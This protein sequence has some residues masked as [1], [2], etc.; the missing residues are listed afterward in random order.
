MIGKIISG[1][2]NIFGGN[3]ADR[4]RKEIEPIVLKINEHFASYTQLSNDELRNKTNEFIQRI[5]LHLTEIDGRITETREQL[6]QTPEDQTDLRDGLFHEIDELEKSRDS[7]LEEILAEILPE[8]FAVVKEAAR[9]LTENASLTFTATDLDREIAVNRNHVQIQGEKA[10]YSNEW[11]AAGG[12]IRWNMV[13]YDVQL[14]GGIALHRGKI[15]EMATG[16][17][18]T[19]V[20]T[21]PVYLNAL[22]KRG[23][24]VVT[25]NDYLAR[26]DCEWN[27]PLYNFLGLSV[28]CL[29][30][31][32]PN[33]TTRRKAYLADI[34]YGTN[35]EFGFD[36]LRDNM[37]HG[38]EEQVQKKHHFAIVDEVDSVLI[39]DARTPLII[40]GPTPHGDDQQ[41]DALK[42]RIQKLVE[43]QKKYI[44]TALNDAKRLIGEGNTGSKEGEGGLALLRAHRGLPKNRAL[45]KFL[46][47]SGMRTILTKTY[48]Y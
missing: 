22:G 8:A 28:D 5:N 15:A 33:S 41:F 19:L 37:A 13:H 44:V 25:V 9:R 30:Y 12:Q 43:A 3:K 20:S 1:L 24:H 47:E 40:S 7:S 21:L 34:T 14:I 35:N 18:K 11:T 4:D 45:I 26:R 6:S 29:E 32:Q 36:Y 23:V 46:S 38:P 10:V 48:S 31:H 17:G 39:D 42:P 2:S 16:E 27:G